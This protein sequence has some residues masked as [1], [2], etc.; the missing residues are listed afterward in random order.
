ML[1]PIASNGCFGSQR[2]LRLQKIN[3]AYLFVK[4]IEYGLGLV[5]LFCVKESVCLWSH[6]LWIFACRGNV[7]DVGWSFII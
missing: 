7:G 4:Y 5:G 6:F 2:Q 1:G 3:K